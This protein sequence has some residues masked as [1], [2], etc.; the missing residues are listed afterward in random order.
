MSFDLFR[1]V[2]ISPAEI[3]FT[4]DKPIHFLGT[5]RRYAS[6]LS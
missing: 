6:G 3:S 2:L 4:S 1:G 5:H